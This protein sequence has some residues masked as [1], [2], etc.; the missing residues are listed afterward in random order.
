MPIFVDLNYGH[1]KVTDKSITGLVGFLGGITITWYTKYQSS[2]MASVFST[3]FTSL[4]KAIEE[5]VTCRYYCRAFG[6][7]LTHPTIICE[8]NMP[9]VVNT[10][11]P[12]SNL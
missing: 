7:R 11:N 1:N 5:V 8:D 9:V 12:E 3:K 4:K 2:V 6:I 10:S